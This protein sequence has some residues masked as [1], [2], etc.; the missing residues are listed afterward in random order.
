MMHAMVCENAIGIGWETCNVMG[1]GKVEAPEAMHAATSREETE[2]C[3][4]RGTAAERRRPV[5][6]NFRQPIWNKLERILSYR[7]PEREAG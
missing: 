5:G 7:I 3:P 1:R 2:L 6:R 4:R